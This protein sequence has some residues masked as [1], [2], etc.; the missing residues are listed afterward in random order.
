MWKCRK[1]GEEKKQISFSCNETKFKKLAYFFMYM[2]NCVYLTTTKDH[3]NGKYLFFFTSGR[4]KNSVKKKMMEPY[5][6]CIFFGEFKV[7]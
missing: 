7:G 4:R 2:N 5:M 6:I 3:M 1:K